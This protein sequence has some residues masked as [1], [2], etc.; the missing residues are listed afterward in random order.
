MRPDVIVVIAPEGQ[1]LAGI[2]EAVE[3]L[4]VQ[5]FVPQTAVEA[6]DQAKRTSRS[7]RSLG[8][9]YQY[10]YIGRSPAID[11]RYARTPIEALILSECT[12]LKN[13]P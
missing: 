13:R 7:S 3:D 12:L 10:R 6:F 9:V 1:L 8:P 4:F 2:G 5:A 11:C